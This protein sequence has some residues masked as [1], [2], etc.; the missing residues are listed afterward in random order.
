MRN[1]VKMLLTATLLLLVSITPLSAQFQQDFTFR[2]TGSSTEYDQYEGSFNGGIDWFQVFCVQPFQHVYT[3]E[4]YS[5]A[6]VTNLASGNMTYTIN[7]TG[8]GGGFTNAPTQYVNAAGLAA[9]MPVYTGNAMRNVQYAIWEAMGFTVNTF[10]AYDSLAV[11][12]RTNE[13]GLFPQSAANWS[14]ITDTGKNRQEFIYQVPDTPQEVVPEP[15][16][17]TLLATG[18]VGLAVSRKKRRTAK[19]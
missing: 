11:T 1:T 6:W 7:G 19:S 15:A 4:V 13:A 18:L 10:A 16:T 3:G 12:A 14:V 2:A 5:D 8:V 17:M 9:V